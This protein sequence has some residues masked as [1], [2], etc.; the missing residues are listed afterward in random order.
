MSANMIRIVLAI[1]ALG[2]AGPALAT[3][4]LANSFCTFSSVGTTAVWRV[5][6]NLPGQL[7]VRSNG[8]ISLDYN[9]LLNAVDMALQN[10][11]RQ[12]RAHERSR[13]DSVTSTCSPF[14]VDLNPCIVAVGDGSNGGSN[15][16]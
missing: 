16:C 14:D 12:S 13:V 15:M 8:L 5:D 11:S 1:S 6:S 7:N 9:E 3:D 4:G 10:E 2:L